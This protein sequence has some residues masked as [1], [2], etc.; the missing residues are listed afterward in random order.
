MDLIMESM[1]A[2]NIYGLKRQMVNSAKIAI[3]GMTENLKYEKT[4]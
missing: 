2:Q 4:T 1:N 3:S